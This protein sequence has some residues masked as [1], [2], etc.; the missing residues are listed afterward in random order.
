MARYI[1]VYRETLSG[2]LKMRKFHRMIN[3]TDFLQN[4]PEYISV[5]IAEE[6]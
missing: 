1:L 4:N 3:L 2:E 6:L 5:V